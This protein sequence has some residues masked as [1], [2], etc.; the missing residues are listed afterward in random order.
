MIVPT[1]LLF[2]VPPKYI[3][4][5]AGVYEIGREGR[6]DNPVRKVTVKSFS[7]L[8]CEVTNR[9]FDLFVKTTKYVTDAE[10]RKDAMVFR[11]GLKEF[12]WNQDKTANWRFPNGQSKGGIEQKM[13][14]PVT[15]ISYRDAEAYCKWAKVRLPTIEEWEIA[16]RAGKKGKYFFGSDVKEI[17]KYGNI[18]HGKDHLVADETDGYMLTSPVKSFKPN[19]WKIYDMYGNVFEFC[20]GRVLSD[21]G[22]NDVVHSRGGSWWCSVASCCAFNSEDIGKVKKYAS[23]SNQGFRVVR[24]K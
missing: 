3:T 21:R 11:V 24:L 10:K 8:E 13:D 15:T 17:I 20:S 5:P 18:W 6:V 22:R 16:S 7:I 12:R 23:F 19:P 14:H 1:L 9:D 4:V 2:R